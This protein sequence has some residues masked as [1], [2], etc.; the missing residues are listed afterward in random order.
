LRR[1]IKFLFLLLLAIAALPAQAEPTTALPNFYLGVDAGIPFGTDQPALIRQG[2]VSRVGGSAEVNQDS[3]GINGRLFAGYQVTENIGI[4]LSVF[5]TTAAQFSLNGTTASRATYA[6][7]ASMQGSG[8]TYAAM[9]RPSVSTGWNQLFFRL[10]G[11][12]STSDTS[13]QVF[14]RVEAVRQQVLQPAMVCCLV[15][16]LMAALMSDLIGEYSWYSSIQLVAF[17]ARIARSYQWA[18]CGS[19][20]LLAV[21]AGNAVVADLYARCVSQ[22][23][24]LSV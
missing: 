23:I 17:Q 8:F 13:T 6:G 1:Q 4:E 15:W 7:N 21:G 16:V 12:R 2:V 11:H 3:I 14:F 24:S 19:F 5:R 22:I 10:G 9:L 18:R 20:S